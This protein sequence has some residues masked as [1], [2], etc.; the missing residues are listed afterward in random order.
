MLGI[1]FATYYGMIEVA[2]VGARILRVGDLFRRVDVVLTCAFRRALPVQA[3]SCVQ[4][5]TPTKL[6]WCLGTAFLLLLAIAFSLKVSDTFSRRWIYTFA[7][8]ACAATIVFRLA[9]YAFIQ[10]LSRAGI[11]VRNVAILGGGEQGKRLLAHIARTDPAFINVIGVFDDRMQR[12]GPSVEG[13]PVLGNMDQLIDFSR[14]NRIDD[15]VVALPWSADERLAGIVNKLRELPV[16][17][18]LGTD[19][20]GFRFNCRSAPSHFDQIPVVEVMNTP[21]S[22]WNVR[23][24]DARG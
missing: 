19:L 12:I 20:A 2:G 23:V 1:G 4:L 8:S 15:V 18:H 14:K 7:F 16:N 21:M 6:S 11:C 13:C 22:G 17:I 9:G 3:R 5:N 10:Q 24:E